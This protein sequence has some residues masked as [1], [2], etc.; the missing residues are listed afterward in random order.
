MKLENELMMPKY[1]IAVINNYKCNNI[2]EERQKNSFNYQELKKYLNYIGTKKM[3]IMIFLYNNKKNIHELLYILETF[4]NIEDYYIIY[5]DFNYL[6]FFSLLL[7]EER[8]II[9][10]SYSKNFIK[11]IDNK[12]G[13]KKSLEKMIYSKIIIDIINNFKDLDEYNIENDGKFIEKLEN[14]NIK[15]IRENIHIL[16]KI[17]ININ[18]DD[19]LNMNIDELYSLILISLFKTKKFR[20]YEYTV[21]I[22]KQMHMEEININ[23]KI[24]QA[25]LKFKELDNEHLKEFEISSQKD[26]FNNKKIN[27][28]Y[29]ILKYILKIPM[30]IYQMPWLLETKKEIMKLI[31]EKDFLNVDIENNDK[32][33]F[34][35][36]SFAD[37]EYYFT[38]KIS[39]SDRIKLNEIMNY[40][41]NYLFESKNNEIN[42]IKNIIKNNK[43][44][45]EKYLLDYDSAKKWNQRI[46]IIK[47]LFYEDNKKIKKSEENINKHKK[48]FESI[49]MMIKEKKFK[50]LKNNTKNALYKYFTDIN[51]K[52]IINEIFTQDM[53]DNFI[54]E[55]NKMKKS[56]E[57]KKEEI[58]IEEIKNE[59]LKNEELKNGE[60]YNSK[61]N[62]QEKEGNKKEEIQQKNSTYTTNYLIDKKRNSEQANTTS[63]HLI[64]QKEISTTNTRESQKKTKIEE[65][66][67]ENI[68]KDNYSSTNSENLLYD[69]MTNSK[70]Q[71]Y[72]NK[73]GITPLIEINEIFYG[74]NNIKISNDKYNQIYSECRGRKRLSKI[75]KYFL[76]F[77]GF[78]EEIK[79]R[80]EEEF[81]YDYRLRIK[82]NFKKEEDKNSDND[83]FNIDCI[84]TFYTPDINEGKMYKDDNILK[85]GTNSI[86]Q[87]FEYLIKEINND[88][89]QNIKYIND[90][91]QNQSKIN[92]KEKI[93]QNEDNKNNVN[94]N[95]ESQSKKI[96]INQNKD[97][98]SQAYSKLGKKADKETI[99]E[100][101]DIV[102]EG[103][104]FNGFITELDNGYYAL[105][106][107]NNT[108]N[109]YDINFKDIL[110]IKGFNDIISNI[111]EKINKDIGKSQKEL[112]VCTK[113]DISLVRIDLE[114]LTYKIDSTPLK[115]CNFNYLEMNPLNSLLLSQKGLF[116]Y[117]DF[118]N[119]NRREKR[120]TEDVF[121]RGFKMNEN[122]VALV[123]NNVLPKGSDKLIFF[124]N[125]TNK[126]SNSIEDYS[127]A[128][129]QNG[130]GLIQKEMSMEKPTSKKKKKNRNK[131]Q[132]YNKSKLYNILICACKRYNNDQNNGILI[133]IENGGETKFINNP[134]LN[135]DNFEVNCI[136]PLRQIE[137]NN[138]NYENIDEEYKKNITIKDT[139][140]FL[141]GGFDFDKRQGKI[142]LY[143]LK[144]NDKISETEIKY[145]Q[146]IEFA[147]NNEFDGFE[148]SV[149]CIIQSKISGNI[150]VGS[151]DEKVYLLTAPNLEYYLN[152]NFQHS[153]NKK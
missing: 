7:T 137:N 30:Y 72:S 120:I 71:L 100:F 105:Y 8:E 85:N 46:G 37:S 33:E 48:S 80:L 61:N 4:I 6:F 147:E 89:Y 56:L 53:I 49:E 110:E 57:I 60:L 39:D 58:K 92:Q 40:Y 73:K 122:F 145:I 101:I 86:T 141:A 95:K 108:L 20:D 63:Q 25:I 59:K 45:Y 12:L 118:F 54:N 10:Y 94:M 84:Y 123:S 66:K 140:F 131:N 81:I 143:N 78:I 32:L 103:C 88:S 23:E 130:I 127:F 11:N 124:N 14:E 28:Y 18:I 75:E 44:G 115:K 121:Y 38:K 47:Y 111:V 65:T 128:L 41:I 35:L 97:L 129:S 134:F 119:Y 17:N 116:Y 42:E 132:T 55:F 114:K 152:E 144:F 68:I 113:S 21:D 51:N 139:T 109:I 76:K 67:M 153:E 9:N 150:F 99:L 93:Y 13:M 83:A 19:L 98:S 82:L 149:N 107:K 96:I 133:T 5:D 26:L 117:T 148:T 79:K 36:K 3:N 16:E 15:N 31:K 135:T 77:N 104:Y 52:E 29:I 112:I 64:S 126:L 34:V 138:K 151:Y 136:C 2:L 50:K 27:F 87:G 106:K 22:I 70:F 102:G 142:K 24:F 74:K 146:D 1:K 69:I 91:I 43:N 90:N 62:E 125:I